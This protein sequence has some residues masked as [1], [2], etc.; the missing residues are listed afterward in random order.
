MD[1]GRDENEW[2]DL[3]EVGADFLR[4]RARLRKDTSYTELNATLLR[5]THHRPFDFEQASERAAMGHLLGKIVEADYRHTKAMLSS[6][7]LYLNAN[8]PGTG[9]FALATE[10]GLLAKGGDKLAFWTGQI[11]AVFDHYATS[12]GAGTR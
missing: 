5:R 11:N 6:L 1:F 4:E 3:I 2:A 10:M 7:V 8:D 12:P 9:F